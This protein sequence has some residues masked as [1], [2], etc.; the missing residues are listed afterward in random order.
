MEK[1]L[2]LVTLGPRL[3]RFILWL[4][5]RFIYYVLKDFIFADIL[6]EQ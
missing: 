6:R 2:Q 5:T 3:P 1:S 4:L